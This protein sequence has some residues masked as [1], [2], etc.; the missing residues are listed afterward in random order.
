MVKNTTLQCALFEEISDKPIHAIF[1]QPNSS[2][3][4]GSILLKAADERLK[5][6]ASLAQCLRDRRASR[7]IS[8][9]YLEQLRQRIYGLACG[10]EDCNDAARLIDDPMHKLSIGRDPHSAACFSTDAV[11]F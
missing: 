1:D 2:V 7:Q 8:H 6:T 10:Y 5:L 9:S 4:G 3:D 11:S